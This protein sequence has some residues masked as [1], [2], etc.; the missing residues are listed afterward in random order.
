MRERRS[1]AFSENRL[2]ILFATSE[3]VPY[4]KTGGLAD[5]CGTLPVELKKLGADIFI[6]LPEYK[7]IRERFNL[8]PVGI[9]VSIPIYENGERVIKQAEVFVCEAGEVPCYFIKRDEFFYRDYLYATPK[10]DYEDNATRFVFFSRAV[11]EFILKSGIEFNIIHCHDWQSALVPVYLKTLYCQEPIFKKTRS[12]LTIHNLGYQ[13][14]FW[15]WDIKQIG[16]DW[17]YFTPEYL[18]YY[19]KVNFLKGGIVFADKITTVSPSYAKEI[20]TPEFGEGLEGVLRKRA[21]DIV[22]ILNG[23][24]YSIWNPETDAKIPA[25]Y[26]PADLSGKSICKKVLKEELGLSDEDKPIVGCVSRLA[27]QKGVDIIAGAMKDIVDMGFQLVILGTGEEK[28]QE[29]LRKEGEKFSG[30]VAVRIEFNDELAH[31]IEAGADIFLMPS[32]YEPC[33]LNQLISLKYGTVPVVRAVGGL[34]DTIEE[35]NPQTGQGT[36]FLFEKPEPE[37]MLRALARARE[38]YNSPSLWKKLMI[39]GMKKDF[40]WKESARKYLE[41]YRSLVAG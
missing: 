27:Y 25:N 38:I 13:G 7:G 28:Y 35:F 39:N 20:Q 26:S 1:N 30:K 6:I 41:L 22:G 24:D 21:K 19:G 14:V 15:K 2:R 18:E 16:L 17:S 12:I 10:G 11:V 37:D 4:A 29:I 9:E 5:V 31:K 32:R 36:G 23:I 8:K 33:G 34:K 40:S 3:A